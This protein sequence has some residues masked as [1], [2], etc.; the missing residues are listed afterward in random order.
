M[1]K[2][3]LKDSRGRTIGTIETNGSKTII[4]DDRGRTLGSFD[5]KV[6]KDDRGRTIGKG[7]LLTMLLNK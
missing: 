3:Y 5:G 4:K 7:N 1:S 2:E 6:T